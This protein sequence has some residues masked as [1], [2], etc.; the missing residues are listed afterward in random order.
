MGCRRSPFKY[1]NHIGYAGDATRVTCAS[2]MTWSYF[3]IQRCDNFHI[4][5]NDSSLI[6]VAV[7]PRD[8]SCSVIN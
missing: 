6:V 2:R 5:I 3:L 4:I 8:G 1:G 7:T